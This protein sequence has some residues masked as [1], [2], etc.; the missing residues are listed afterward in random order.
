MN[1][2]TSEDERAYRWKRTRLALETNDFSAGNE[3]IYCWTL[4]IL[5]LEM[6]AFQMRELYTLHLV[7]NVQYHR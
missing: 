3:S 7:N 2:F 6:N 4:T 5:A 1:T